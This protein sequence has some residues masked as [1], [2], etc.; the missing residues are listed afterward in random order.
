MYV[1]T[2]PPQE[3]GT[4]SDLSQQGMSSLFAH[5]LSA[6]EVVILNKLSFLLLKIVEHVI[7]W[8]SS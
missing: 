3:D 8:W 4:I 7:L 2:F 5:G 1:A 6:L